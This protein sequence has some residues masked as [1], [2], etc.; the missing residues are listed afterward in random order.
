[1][2][3]CRVVCYLTFESRSINSATGSAGGSC[4]TLTAYDSLQQVSKRRD[5]VPPLSW[6]RYPSHTRKDRLETRSTSA[7]INSKGTAGKRV[8]SESGL[9]WTTD[10]PP[11]SSTESTA[12]R[13][14]S[15]PTKLAQSIRSGFT[16][17]NPVDTSSVP[18]G[19]NMP[20]K[21]GKSRLSK[22]APATQ[23]PT[24]LFIPKRKKKACLPASDVRREPD[25]GS[26]GQSVTICEIRQPPT[27]PDNMPSLR[28]SESGQLTEI[29][30]TPQSSFHP[31]AKEAV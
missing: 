2:P 19:A 1:M 26:G 28:K 23:S 27:T 31:D 14:S 3:P 7:T 22:P 30:V 5:V 20:Y 4:N 24:R 12:I 21:T 17:V 18:S 11:T 16:K 8:I 15:F 10:R 13:A 25:E 6:A 9:Q 29:F